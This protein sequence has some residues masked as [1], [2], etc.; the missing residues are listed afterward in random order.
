M[1]DSQDIVAAGFEPVSAAAEDLLPSGFKGRLYSSLERVA[2]ISPDLDEENRLVR[3]ARADLRCNP[4]Y[5]IDLGQT[6]LQSIRK[7]T[8]PIG[9]DHA[10]TLSSPYHVRGNGL[11]NRP[12]RLLLGDTKL[13]AHARVTYVSLDLGG[14]IGFVLA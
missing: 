12:K 3:R 1:V 10:D 2:P 7:T 14:W 4:L 9:I 5:R 8:I 13:S 6:D 11:L